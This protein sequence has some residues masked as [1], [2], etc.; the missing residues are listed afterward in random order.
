M[1]NVIAEHWQRSC[2]SVEIIEWQRTLNACIWY[3]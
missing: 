3:L 2:D 1:T